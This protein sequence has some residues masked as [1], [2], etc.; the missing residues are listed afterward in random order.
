MGCN[1]SIIGE[2]LD[3]DALETKL[4][5]PG[6]H[7][8]YKGVPRYRTKPEKEKLPYSYMSTAIS[9]AGFDDMEQQVKDVISYLKQHFDTLKLVSGVKEVQYFNLGFGVDYANKFCQ[10]M[11]LPPELVRL[12]GELGMSIELSLY[13]SEDY[14][15]S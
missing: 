5:L 1:L 10:S 6:F 14:F 8:N 12:A 7:K 15:S 2:D 3:V 11:Y 9:D 4:G 13:T